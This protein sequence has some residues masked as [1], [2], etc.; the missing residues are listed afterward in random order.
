MIAKWPSALKPR[1][2]HQMN[3]FHVVPGAIPRGR[4]NIPNWSTSCQLGFFI[5]VHD[6]LEIALVV[7]T[8]NMTFLHRPKE[9]YKKIIQKNP[10]AFI[11]IL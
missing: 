11:V 7:T 5:W 9:L 10:F 3:L 1:S 8:A 2:D 6:Y 4:F